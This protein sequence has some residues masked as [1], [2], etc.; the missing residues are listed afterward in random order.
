MT[1][2]NRADD[3]VT[4]RLRANLSHTPH[5]RFGIHRDAD[6]A[7]AQ[8]DRITSGAGAPASESPPSRGR[9]ARPAVPRTADDLVPPAADISPAQLCHVQRTNSPAQRWETRSPSCTTYSGRTRPPG[10]GDSP[11]QLCHGQP[12]T[13]GTMAVHGLSTFTP[14]ARGEAAE[15]AFGRPRTASGSLPAESREPARFVEIDP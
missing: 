15:S 9:L 2:C 6:F 12:R 14:D 5:S 3:T 11:A 7:V 10:R 4:Q 1:G 13:E 8:F